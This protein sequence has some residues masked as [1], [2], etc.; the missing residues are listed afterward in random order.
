[1]SQFDRESCGAGALASV[2]FFE[3]PQ[4]GRLCHKDPTANPN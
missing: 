2:F 1:M 3:K 4:P